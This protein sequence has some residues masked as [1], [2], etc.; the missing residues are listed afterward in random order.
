MNNLDWRNL[1]Q[2]ELNRAYNN[3]A[4]IPNRD[5]IFADWEQRSADISARLP[6]HLNLQY[7][8]RPRNRLDF[9]KAKEGAPTLLFI[10]GG[11]WQMHSKE[12]F[13]AMASGPMAHGI[14]VAIIEYTLTP[15]ITLD[16]IVEEINQGLDFLVAH[17]SSLGGDPTRI[18][19]AGSSAGGH[20]TA[21][22]LAHP[23]VIG[24]VGI[25]GL[26][27]LEPI[28]HSYINVGLK[29]NKSMSIH[30]SP[31]LQVGGA[32]T[33]IALLVGSA[34]LPLMR[35]QTADFAIHRIQYRLPVT[36]EEIP[37]ANHFTILSELISPTGR[38]TALVRALLE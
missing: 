35:K 11:Y 32:D 15:E 28:R 8:P 38:I 33:P 25:S 29:L 9:F 23:S 24:G 4:A 26:Y 19:V 27:D 6:E 20:L 13:R 30:E 12:R 7:G 21:M 3:T 17:S 36:Y 14:N 16:Q 18:V 34:E 37:H 22:V 2:E 5:Q 1:S 31:T 10:H